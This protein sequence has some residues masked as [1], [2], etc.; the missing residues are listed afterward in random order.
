MGRTNRELLEGKTKDELVRL[1][2]N[3]AMLTKSVINDCDRLKKEN[4]D[5][6]RTAKGKRVLLV[7]NMR[8]S[9]EID[10]LKKTISNARTARYSTEIQVNCGKV[11]RGHDY[12]INTGRH[13]KR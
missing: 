5:L 7:D 10:A 6:K 11:Y 9:I 12:N 3:Q 8:L 13:V 1:A 2:L 4:D